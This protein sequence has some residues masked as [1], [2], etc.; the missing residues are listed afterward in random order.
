MTRTKSKAVRRLVSDDQRL[1][2]TIL[3]KF[4]GF[5]NKAIACR[6]F[7]TKKPSAQ[8]VASVAGYKSRQGVS[9]LWWRNIE[10]AQARQYADLQTC[11]LTTPRTRKHRR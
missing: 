10:S 7:H 1:L 9:C 3:T 2:I 11:P 4:G 8:E 5:S 6:I